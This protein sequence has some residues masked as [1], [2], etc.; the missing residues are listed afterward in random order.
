M[1]GS[2]WVNPTYHMQPAAMVGGQRRRRITRRQNLPRSNTTPV[3]GPESS[4][5]TN[6]AGGDPPDLDAQSG[7]PTARPSVAPSSSMMDFYAPTGG[8]P[9]DLRPS[10]TSRPSDVFSKMPTA[11]SPTPT[12]ASVSSS[13]AEGKKK[14]AK[15]S[16]KSKDQDRPTSSHGSSL[17]PS[18]LPPITPVKAAQL[19][20]V[21]PSTDASRSGSA[22]RQIPHDGDYDDATV[23]PLLHKQASMPMLTNF[24]DVTSRQ[25]KFREEDVAP[26]QPKSKGFWGGG[27]KKAVKLLGLLPSM[28]SSSKR[29]AEMERAAAESLMHYS[30]RDTE[31]S[32]SSAPDLHDRP[33][34]L[35]AAARPLPEAPKRRARKKHPKSLDKMAPIT[36]MSHDELRSS[37][38]KSEHNTELDIISEYEDEYPPHSSAPLSRS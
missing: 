27:N 6:S 16:F 33:R 5:A 31:T 24:K 22:G 34:L 4:A 18:P 23:R 29:A 12:A 25:T 37:Y 10:P 38:R 30:E 14:H 17:Q 15:F 32:Y 20:G 8:L 35:P 9:N 3:L 36:E 26:D 11:Y 13:T 7:T 1:V 2:D 28:G 19:L 21:D